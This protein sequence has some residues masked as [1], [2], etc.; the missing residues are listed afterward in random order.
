[1]YVSNRNFI[2]PPRSLLYN[3]LINRYVLQYYYISFRTTELIITRQRVLSAFHVA[4]EEFNTDMQINDLDI[5]QTNNNCLRIQL[6]P[7]DPH[8]SKNGEEKGRCRI[9]CFEAFTQPNQ[10]TAHVKALDMILLMKTSRGIGF[11]NSVD[12]FFSVG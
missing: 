7:H 4:W 11:R 3:Y 8:S 12:R 10:A 9:S 6:S 1:M 5:G 2:Q